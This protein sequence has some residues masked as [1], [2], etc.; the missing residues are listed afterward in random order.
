[1]KDHKFSKTSLRIG[2]ISIRFSGT[3][4]VSLE[5]E[6]WAEVLERLGHKSYYFAGISDWY[7]DRTKVVP[8]ANF[9]HPEIR[10]INQ[11]VF[12]Q[13]VRPQEIT[14]KIQKF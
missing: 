8:E 1:M 9:K 13:V 12:S 11:V 7:P 4:G 2:F 3:D 6:K 10:S 14:D 5:T